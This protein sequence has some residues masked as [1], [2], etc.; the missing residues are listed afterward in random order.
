MAKKR[1]TIDRETKREIQELVETEKAP[2]TPRKVRKG[3]KGK[4]RGAKHGGAK[5]SAGASRGRAH[6]HADLRAEIEGSVSHAGAT[7]ERVNADGM[8]RE[9]VR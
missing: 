2:R 1:E 3:R 8:G 7:N 9:R 6:K 4:K 5:R